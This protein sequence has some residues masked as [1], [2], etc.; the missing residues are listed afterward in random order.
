MLPAHSETQ[1][2]DQDENDA[3]SETKIASENQDGD[4]NLQ[5]HS[6]SLTGDRE[7]SENV[8]PDTN[9][10]DDLNAAARL[11]NASS[12]AGEMEIGA[13]KDHRYVLPTVTSEIAQS[14][15][16]E[17]TTTG[18]DHRTDGNCSDEKVSKRTTNRLEDDSS[19][20]L[21]VGRRMNEAS[22]RFDSEFGSPQS[23]SQTILDINLSHISRKPSSTL[24]EPCSLP[25]PEL[26]MS[27]SVSP[28]VT[29]E[30]RLV[31]AHDIKVRA[32]SPSRTA[33]AGKAEEAQEIP[34]FDLV[35][36]PPVRKL[37]EEHIL[38]SLNRQR[39]VA[40]SAIWT[41]LRTLAPASCF[42]VD[43]LHFEVA[44]TPR[45]VRESDLP[46][47]VNRIFLPV[48]DPKCKHWSLAVISFQEPIVRTYD[49]L[50]SLRRDKTRE[51]AALKKFAAQSVADDN[52][53][54]GW[55]IK[56]YLN[57]PQQDNS[58]DCGIFIIIVA[59]QLM[60]GHKDLS[61]G[62]SDTWREVCISILEGSPRDVPTIDSLS[63]H[64]A[65]VT[66]DNDTRNANQALDNHRMAQQKTQ[67]LR[68]QTNGMNEILSVLKER[69]A[70]LDWEINTLKAE[71]DRIL[72]NFHKLQGHHDDYEHFDI[73]FHEPE[74]FQAL[75]TH[76]QSSRAKLQAKVDS[77]QAL[78]H[79]KW[80]LN[81]SKLAVSYLRPC[82]WRFPAAVPL[83]E[84]VSDL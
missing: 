45:P 62:D 63:Q 44:G 65:Q 17:P 60:M 79:R 32:D 10:E 71:Y 6:P 42:V 46:E 49:P 22:Q 83:F 48:H 26:T 29:D 57:L 7:G 41:V 82:K 80:R 38:E 2:D 77:A 3:T 21:E 64:Q 30:K 56:P 70:S 9:C 35:S 47:T 84:P 31:P 58:Y 14:E 25:S 18:A 74:F 72:P 68:S 37:V 8:R 36:L 28:H 78:Y 13:D 67:Q 53:W 59:L 12:D 27:S 50:F 43:P 16:R 55:N 66:G 33:S 15:T 73:L 4:L 69:I 81:A 11:P 39:K 75:K 34:S 76:L 54:R 24:V 19:I 61:I 52:D 40:G 5:R 51:H 20:S 23:A 1:D